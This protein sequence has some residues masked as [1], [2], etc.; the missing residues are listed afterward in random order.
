MQKCWTVCCAVTAIAAGLIATKATEAADS[1]S[2]AN[3]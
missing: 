3:G 1:F 2:Q